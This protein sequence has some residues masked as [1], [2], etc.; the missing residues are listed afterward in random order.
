MEWSLMDLFTYLMNKNDNNVPGD[1]FSSLLGNGQSGTYQTFTGT[2]ISA[3][4]TKKGK[5][6]INLLGNTSQTGTPTPSTP[7]PVN[8]VSGDNEVVVCGKNL[9]SLPNISSYTT[10]GI[11]CSVNNGIITDEFITLVKIECQRV[12]TNYETV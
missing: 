7:I 11:T 1:L 5:M 2:S 3:N 8:V 4:N 6:K 9:L 12:L 10:Q